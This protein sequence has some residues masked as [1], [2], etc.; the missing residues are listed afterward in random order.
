MS[1]RGD[2]LVPKGRDAMLIHSG[3]VRLLGHVS[4]LRVLKRLPGALSPGFVILFLIGLRSTEMTVSGALVQLS[5]SLV[6]FV[7]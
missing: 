1:Q 7:M 3:P 2:V 4:L 6:I 5:S